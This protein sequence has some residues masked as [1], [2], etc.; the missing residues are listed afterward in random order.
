[1]SEQK[2]KWSF[3]HKN[4]GLII[5]VVL[6]LFITAFLLSWHINGDLYVTDEQDDNSVIEDNSNILFRTVYSCGHE[7]EQCLE[8]VPETLEGF[9]FKG[10]TKERLKINLPPDWDV[11]SF[12]PGDV[13]LIRTKDIPCQECSELKYIG[14]YEDRIAIYQG[15]RPHGV[16][17][18]IT[19][20]EVKEIYREELKEG[21]PF[22]T[23]EEKK[24]ILESY[25]S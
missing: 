1:M 20:F 16:L 23:E 10:L 14:I 22:S 13:V 11:S 24:R 8:N 18:E 7:V 17:K 19:D 9:T 15:E 25:T 21:I 4:Y 12:S 3:P 2:N 6:F 5:I